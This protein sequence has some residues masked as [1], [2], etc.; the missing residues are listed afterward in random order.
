M[1]L[2]AAPTLRLL[3]RDCAVDCFQ[4]TW[5]RM[6]SAWTTLAVLVPEEEVRKWDEEGT[7]KRNRKI[8]AF[9]LRFFTTKTEYEFSGKVKNSL[10]R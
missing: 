3:K 6:C 10:V 5:Y 7:G 4:G 2:T 1:N 8:F 9:L